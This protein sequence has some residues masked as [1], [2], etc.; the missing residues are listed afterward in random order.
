MIL[1]R[2]QRR[3]VFEEKFLLQ[4]FATEF[5]VRG[6]RLVFHVI[7]FLLGCGDGFAGLISANGNVR[8]LFD[9]KIF[10]R[11]VRMLS[12]LG[13]TFLNFIRIGLNIGSDRLAN[14]FYF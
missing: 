8:N 13:M 3:F 1:G 2:S 11:L 10:N 9:L 7:F 4:I 14:L 12:L 6:G 5:G